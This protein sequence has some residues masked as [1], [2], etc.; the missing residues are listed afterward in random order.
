MSGELLARINQMREAAATLRGS[1][2]RIG[3]CIDGPG[4]GEFSQRLQPADP[5]SAGG[6]A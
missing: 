1:A 6:G 2:A 4:S 3:D 5:D